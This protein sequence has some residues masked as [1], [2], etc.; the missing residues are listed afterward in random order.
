MARRAPS[1]DLVVVLIVWALMAILL[2]VAAWTVGPR[3]RTLLGWSLFVT[4]GPPLALVPY[5]LV[6]TFLRDLRRLAIARWGRPRRGTSV[7]GRR[8]LLLLAA[9][10]CAAIPLGALVWL[11]AGPLQPFLAPVAA[12]LG[13]H[14]GSGR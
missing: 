11:V 8:V 14:F 7:D 6:D 5:A 3:P 4:V 13:R 1:L 12:F 2:V 9:A 10:A